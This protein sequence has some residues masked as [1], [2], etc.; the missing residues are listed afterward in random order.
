V[1]NGDERAAREESD[2][3]RALSRDDVNVTASSE[4]L[5]SHFFPGKADQLLGNPASV[6]GTDKADNVSPG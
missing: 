2:P 4:H 5:D 3:D 6:F 1:D